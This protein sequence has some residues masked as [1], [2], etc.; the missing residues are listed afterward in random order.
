MDH[1]NTSCYQLVAI[2]QY[3]VHRRGPVASN[4]AE[5]VAFYCTK[6]Q[7]ILSNDPRSGPDA[8]HVEVLRLLSPVV[9]HH[10]DG[11]ARNP[12]L[13]IGL[14]SNFEGDIFTLCPL[15]LKPYS[16]GDV[17]FIEGQM[18]VYPNYLSD[19]GDLDILVEG[20]TMILRIINDGFRKV[21][22]DGVKGTVPL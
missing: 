17:I 8:L 4:I 12:H 16:R 15:N 1:W 6:L 20:V 10:H 2:Y 5:G 14:C 7:N 18:E 3:L 13:P 19:D 9:F 11:Q 22:I 21:G